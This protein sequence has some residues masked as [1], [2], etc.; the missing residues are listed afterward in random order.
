MAREQYRRALD[1]QCTE[2]RSD[3]TTSEVIALRVVGELIDM[4][5]FLS[6]ALARSTISIDPTVIRTHH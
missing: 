3:G 6:S 2:K 4:Y 5:S 1:E